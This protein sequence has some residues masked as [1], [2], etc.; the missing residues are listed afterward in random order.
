MPLTSRLVSL[1]LA[2]ISKRWFTT[3]AVQ[4]HGELM[5]WCEELDM[6]G[7]QEKIIEIMLSETGMMRL[8]IMKVC[9]FKVA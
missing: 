7:V 1:L 9:D 4:P 8:P 3:Y 5:V 6:R 2:M